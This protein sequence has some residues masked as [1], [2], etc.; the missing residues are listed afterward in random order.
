MHDMKIG[1]QTESSARAWVT[2]FCV[3]AV[4]LAWTLFIFYTVGVKWPP[5]WDFGA[6]PEVPG[7]S[8]YSTHPTATGEAQRAA[9]LHENAE[10]APQHVKDPVKRYMTKEQPQ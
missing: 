1:Q 5:V 3:A 2:V 4:F 7:L 8:V 9:P 10:F 6:K